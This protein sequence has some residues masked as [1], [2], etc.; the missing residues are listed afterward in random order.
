[1]LGESFGRFWA[2]DDRFGGVPWPV[3]GNGNR[4]GNRKLLR[5]IGAFGDGKLFRPVPV[6]VA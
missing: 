4:P 5:S 3:R 6:G 1:M 2:S